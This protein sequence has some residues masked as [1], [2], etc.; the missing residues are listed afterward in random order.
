MYDGIVIISN[1]Q[2]IMLLD[3][4]ENNYE[5]IQTIEKAYLK[6]FQISNNKIFILE[7]GKNGNKGNIFKYENK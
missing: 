5:I 6:I 3:I 7:N 2:E 1:K 4:K